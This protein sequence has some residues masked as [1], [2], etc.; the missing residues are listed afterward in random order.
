M[1]ELVL[2]TLSVGVCFFRRNGHIRLLPLQAL[3]GPTLRFSRL[4]QFL[5]K[6]LAH[7]E[8]PPS[9]CFLSGGFSST[10]DFIAAPRT[11][12]LNSLGVAPILNKCSNPT[13]YCFCCVS[14]L[15]VEAEF[16]VLS[17]FMHEVNQFLEQDEVSWNH[18]DAHANHDAVELLL[19]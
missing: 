15:R 14:G 17:M 2:V 4:P 6:E 19:F 16:R 7:G 3:I 8:S 12:I 11:T 13:L 1:H 9:T 5:I 10:I 18:A